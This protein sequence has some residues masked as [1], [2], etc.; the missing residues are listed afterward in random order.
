VRCTGCQKTGRRRIAAVVIRCRRKPC[1]DGHHRIRDNWARV[2]FVKHQ[3]R[4]LRTT[5]AQGTSGGRIL[6]LGAPGGQRVAFSVP[7]ERCTDQST[8]SGLARFAAIDMSQR[9][10]NDPTR[11]PRCPIEIHN[12]ILRRLRP[13]V[14]VGRSSSA[15]LMRSKWYIIN[16]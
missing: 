15:S 2:L 3:T 7:P 10:G 9:R 13:Y 5:C 16:V 4:T 11:R 14:S 1:R 12:S 8:E 6:Q